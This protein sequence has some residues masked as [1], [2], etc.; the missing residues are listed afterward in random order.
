MTVADFERHRRET[1][2]TPGAGGDSVR[3]R[4]LYQHGVST[5]LEHR[6]TVTACGAFRFLEH[7]LTIVTVLRRHQ[8]SATFKADSCESSHDLN[9]V[10]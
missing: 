8:A 1:L 5:E 9:I 7:E 2:T 6:P 4:N 10:V 3:R